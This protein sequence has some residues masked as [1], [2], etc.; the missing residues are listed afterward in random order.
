MFRRECRER[1]CRCGLSRMALQIP[2][3]EKEPE[4][5]TQ[6]DLTCT[7]QVFLEPL[8]VRPLGSLLVCFTCGRGRARLG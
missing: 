1:S 7:V 5:K 4:M 3:S 6:L 8:W 2:S